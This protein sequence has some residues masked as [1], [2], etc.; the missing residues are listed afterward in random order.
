MDPAAD[1][2]E[3]PAEHKRG[4]SRI[5][6]IPLVAGTSCSREP[7]RGKTWRSPIADWEVLKVEDAETD[8]MDWPVLRMEPRWFRL[9]RS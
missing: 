7:A 3:P 8:G 2:A 5:Q 4:G 1:I 6:S 9:R